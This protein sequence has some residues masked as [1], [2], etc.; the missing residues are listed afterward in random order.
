MPAGGI[1]FIRSGVCRRFGNGYGKIGH[2]K[3]DDVIQNKSEAVDSTGMF[4]QP[5]CRVQGEAD[6]L[7]TRLEAL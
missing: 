6:D 1:F 2:D 3:Q 7:T 5:I 4:Q